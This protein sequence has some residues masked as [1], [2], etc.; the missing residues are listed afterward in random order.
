MVSLEEF[1]EII[2]RLSSEEKKKLVEDLLDILLSSVNLENVPDE[3]GWR[4]TEAYRE[5]KMHD[6]Q[7]FRELAY[8]ISIAEPSK[9]TKILKELRRE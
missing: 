7:I 3:V 6:L 1:S 4:I 8:A 9:F 2:R 5:G